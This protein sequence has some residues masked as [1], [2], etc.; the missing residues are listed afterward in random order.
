ML[1]HLKMTGRLYV[2]RSDA[3]YHEDRWVHVRFQFENGS[4]LRFSDA[5]KFG[6]IFI[7]THLEDVT[8]RLGPEPLEGSFTLDVF[9]NALARRKGM[10]KPLLLDQT[11]VAGIGNIYADE[12][13]WLARIDPRQRVD[14]LNP[15]AIRQLHNA[16]IEVLEKGIQYEGASI[17]WYRKPD[18]TTGESQNH[19]NVYD[20]Q[21]RPC[22]RCDT[23]IQK[24]WLGQRGTHFCPV[25]QQ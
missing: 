7:A 3:H 15:E 21:D 8:G 9:T 12:A 23:P 18:G 20:Q 25:C 19:F 5:R 14:T 10:V 24:I 22:P 2:A 17:N 13:L 11:L 1:V 16:I 6:R 4:E